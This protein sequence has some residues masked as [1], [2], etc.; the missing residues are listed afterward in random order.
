MV[1]F[2]IAVTGAPGA[3]KSTFCFGLQQWF[4]GVHR[5]Y[6][7]VNLDPG[8]ER[9]AYDCAVDIREL[10]SVKDLTSSNDDDGEDRGGDD[11]G[12]LL[13]GPNGALMYCME[14]LRENMEWLKDKCKPFLESGCTLVFDC[15]G[16]IE[17]YSHHTAMKAMFAE[18]Q[19]N[20]GISLVAVQMI[21]SHHI[22]DAS[23]YIAVLLV[24]LSSM[25]NLE[26]PVVNV[27]SKIDLLEKFGQLDFQLDY[28]TE[29]L[30]LTYLLHHLPQD[31]F[32]ERMLKLSEGLIDV[33]GSY[34]LVDFCALNVEAKEDMQRLVRLID[35]ANGYVYSS[36]PE[37]SSLLRP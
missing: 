21:D 12:L 27:L 37:G 23:K 25:I 2:G 10:I 9:F 22:V 32:S 17:L 3:G 18:M 7:I 20:W 28:Y 24:S 36:I 4:T 35:K 11:D 13:L 19:K 34:N 29:V 15:P 31:P 6:A 1:G 8:A 16:Q 26:L 14:F 33:I 5:K 30:D